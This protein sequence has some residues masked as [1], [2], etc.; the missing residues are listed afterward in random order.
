MTC[1]SKLVTE[2]SD[3]NEVIQHQHAS[4]LSTVVLTDKFCWLLSTR[5]LGTE[6]F[7]VVSVVVGFVVVDLE[8]GF[9]L[10]AL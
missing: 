5:V 1:G 2:F 3:E 9:V 10:D 7:W 8:V 4:I 6:G